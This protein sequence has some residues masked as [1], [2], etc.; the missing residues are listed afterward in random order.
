MALIGKYVFRGSCTTEA[1]EENGQQKVQVEGPCYSCGK[2]VKVTVVAADYLKFE[3][4]A[5][6]QDC[7]PYLTAGQREF[8]ISG[9]CDECWDSMFPPEDDEE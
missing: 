8:L 9:I 5:F 1:V 4:G 7:F 6:A 2:P 3:R